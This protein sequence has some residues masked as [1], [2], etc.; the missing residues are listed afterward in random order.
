MFT[1]S[2]IL[3]KGISLDSSEIRSLPAAQYAAQAGRRTAERASLPDVAADRRRLFNPTGLNPGT[4]E[5]R[6]LVRARCPRTQAQKTTRHTVSPPGVFDKLRLVL[7]VLV[8]LCHSGVALGSPPIEYVKEQHPPKLEGVLARIQKNWMAQKR[9]LAKAT[10]KQYGASKIIGENITV[11]LEPRHGRLSESIDFAALS[12]LGVSIVAQSRHLLEV[13][14]PVAALE[15]LAQVGGVQFVRLPIEPSLHAVVSEGVDRI[16]AQVYLDEGF[17]GRG[18]KVGV[19]D[20]GFVGVQTLQ[21]QRELP[22]LSYRDFTRQG[23]FEQGSLSESAKIHGSACAEIVHDIAPNAEIQL[24]KVDNLVSL[25]NAKDAAIQ[26]GMDI[27]TVSL[28][29]DVAYG[30]GDGTGLACEIVDDAFQNNV[31]WVNAAGNEAKSKISA[32]LHDPDDDGFHNFEGENEI[33]NLKNVQ[34]GNKVKA[35]LTWNE[36]PLTS[37][38]YDLL[39]VRMGTDES[40]EIVE[41]ADT[42]QLQSRPIEFLAFDIRESGT[43]GL[44]IWRASDAKVTLFKLYSPSHELDG[45]V[46]IAG[47]LTSPADARGALTVGALHHWEWTTG[48]I[49]DYSSQGPTFDGR[50]KPDL[51]A[52]A[53][54]R[55][56]SYGSDGYF[57]TSAATPHVAGAAALLKSSDPVHYNARNLY[58]ALVQSTVDMGDRGADNVYGNGRLDL[59]LL[60]PDG[61][62]AM[63]LS[64]TVLDFG[65][66]LLGSSQ[67][68]NLGIVNTGQASLVITNILLPT[69]DYALSR[70]SYTVAPGRSEQVSVSFSPQS[71]GDRSGEMTI[72]SNLPQNTVALRARGIRQPVDPVP[73]ISVDSSRRDF[74]GVEV[75]STKSLTVTVTNSGEASLTITDI[76]ASN[77]QVSVSP[78]QLTIPAK[79]NGYI[80]LRYE[81][82]RA[83]DLSGRVTIYSNDSKTPVVGFPIVGKGLRSQTTSFKLSLVVDAPKDQDVYSTPSD[84]VIA[85]EIHGRQ[86]KDAIGFRALF[87]SDAQSFVFTGFDIG[88]GIPNGHSPG[89][90]YPPDPSSIEVMA[91]SFGGRIAEPS[92]KLGTVRFSVSDTFQTGQVRLR[93]AR[94]RRS[95]K[96]EVFADPVVLKF[97][98]Q[99]ALTADFDGDGTVGFS[100]FLQFAGA[101]GLSRGDARYDARYD[102]DGNGMIGFGDLLIFAGA[103]G[104]QAVSN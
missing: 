83:E 92:A 44:A 7:L 39:L 95:G 78:R 30:F 49:A 81:P 41:R 103:F 71:V 2:D 50:I 51:V 13:S 82:N 23:I 35:V 12:D 10:A 48:P 88:D 56:I 72:L 19:I 15:S 14:A 57:G 54:V 18:I 65:A 64:R 31:L 80:T 94:I 91:A 61:K 8:P 74:G 6:P 89:P 101:F 27:V 62:P 53:G 42:K 52:P 93:Y 55:T 87:D 5:F 21:D 67:T 85:I 4:L 86:V 3:D 63:N 60:P 96:F 66:V 46:S 9:A 24:Y 76:T 90:Y 69:S 40:R 22:D 104:K 68:R 75:G 99:G 16:R 84:G 11:V 70:F 79:Q 100:D 98:K 20:I 37:H 77:E 32:L 34:V 25:E 26:D 47:S 97:S 43:Y 33:V 45:T 102:L 17:T 38:D 1:L 73:T 58:D 59:S 28:G 36:W 29:W